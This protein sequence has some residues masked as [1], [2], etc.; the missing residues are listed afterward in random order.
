MAKF[1]IN[2]IDPDF[3]DITKAHITEA[4]VHIGEVVT[5]RVMSDFVATALSSP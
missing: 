4:L 2:S 3:I 5:N 1:H